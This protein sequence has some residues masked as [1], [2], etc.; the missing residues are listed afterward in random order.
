MKTNPAPAIAL[1]WDLSKFGS[2]GIG[3]VVIDSF[4]RGM[5][6]KGGIRIHPQV[7]EEEIASL[8]R[9]MTLKC[10][11]ANI[12]F[13][14]A[15]GG[16]KLEDLSRIEEAMFAFGR[17]LSKYEI[18][19]ESWCAAPDVN[20]NSE[21]IDAFVAGCASVKGWRKGRLCATGKSTGIPHELGSTGLGVVISI[22]GTMKK[23]KFSFQLS[24]A[25]VIVEGCG[26]VGGNAIKLLLDRKA[27]ILGVSDI[28]GYV[29][30]SKGLPKEA[31]LK[32]LDK[33]ESIKEFAGFLDNVEFNNNP[34]NLLAK[35]ADILILAGLGRSI[36]QDNYSQLKVSLI[37][38]GANIAYTSQEIRDKV[39][40]NGIISVPGIISHG[41]GYGEI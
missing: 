7:T 33:K 25:R 1:K 14:G 18:L 40:A 19:P 24:N 23:M 35:S 29:Y 12:P 4:T 10:I 8:A 31:L 16:I 37:A 3:Y 13:G 26:E 6:A 34:L 41:D 2:K 36:G 32:H 5:P 11:L 27:D 9:E 38:E 30:S 20:T 21:S 15:K 17:V 39:F 22:E 28:T